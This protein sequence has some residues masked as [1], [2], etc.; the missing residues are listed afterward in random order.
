MRQSPC[1]LTYAQHLR[2]DAAFRAGVS[3]LGRVR[4]P[5]GLLRDPLRLR[6]PAL[7]LEGAS[8]RAFMARSHCGAL[9]WPLTRISARG[10]L[11]GPS[12]GPRCT[13]ARPESYLTYYSVPRTRH[14]S[15]LSAWN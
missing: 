6:R 3:V 11:W 7:L 9:F 8:L 2:D 5:A 10:V 14:G 4:V 12:C 1:V 15:G 13:I